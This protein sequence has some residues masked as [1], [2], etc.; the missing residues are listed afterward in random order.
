MKVELYLTPAMVEVADGALIRN[1]IQV[2]ILDVAV[3]AG[4]KIALATATSSWLRGGPARA[5]EHLGE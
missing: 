4:V 3:G 2:G 5:M 1:L